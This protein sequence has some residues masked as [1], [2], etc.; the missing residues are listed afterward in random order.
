VTPKVGVGPV[1]REQIVQAT[2]RCLAR[3][4][5]AGLTMKKVAREAAVSQGILHYYFASKRAILIAALDV[6]MGDLDRRV[7]ALSEGARDARGRLRAVIRG[8]LGL[9]EDSREFW[10]VFVEFWGE[11]MHD[12]EMSR[13]NAALYERLRRT[14]GATVA[15]GTREG[16]FRRVDPVE[17]GAVILALVD[18]LSL[19]RT[20]DARALTLERAARACEDAVTRY[21]AKA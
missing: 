4:G 14:L 3:E 16:V 21:L 12:Q 2:I 18:G 5:Y 17:A 9:A 19:Q 15:L 13:I 11:M 20:F 6:V 10:V 8:C 1:R 7:A